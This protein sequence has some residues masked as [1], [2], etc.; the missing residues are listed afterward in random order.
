MN[1]DP[2]GHEAATTTAMELPWQWP[3]RGE[4][5]LFCTLVV[6]FLSSYFV[7]FRVCVRKLWEDTA[8]SGGTCW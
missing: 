1:P 6:V 3:F 4:M 2:N 7:Q 8:S 5:A